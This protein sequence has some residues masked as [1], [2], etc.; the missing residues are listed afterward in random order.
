MTSVV[1]INSRKMEEFI[2]AV[3][4]FHAQL[5]EKVLRLKKTTVLLSVSHN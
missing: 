3:G 1:K 2:M 5:E 4:W